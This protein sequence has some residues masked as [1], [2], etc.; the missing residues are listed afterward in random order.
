MVRQWHMK[1]KGQIFLSR[2][3]IHNSVMWLTMYVYNSTG[4][5]STDLVKQSDFP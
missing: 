2:S 3:T 1:M 4:Y 5:D